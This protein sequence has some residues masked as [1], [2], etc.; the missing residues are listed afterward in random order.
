MIQ[1]S[2][3]EMALI[4]GTG[5]MLAYFVSQSAKNNHAKAAIITV[6]GLAIL[7][8]LNEGIGGHILYGSV[9]PERVKNSLTNVAV[10]TAAAASVAYLMKRVVE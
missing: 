4:S 1:Q 8:E 5:A 3:T 6:T 2:K 10:K 7:K 9:T